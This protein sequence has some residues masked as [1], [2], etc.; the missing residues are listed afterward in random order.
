M[1]RI[2]GVASMHGLHVF[3]IFR[4]LFLVLAGVCFCL[5]AAAEPDPATAPTSGGRPTA[6]WRAGLSRRGSGTQEW[7]PHADYLAKKLAPRQF[8]IVPLTLDEFRP[9]IRARID[10]VITNTGHYVEL[11]GWR[12]DLAH[13]HHARRRPE[14]PGG[15]LWRH[16]HRPRRARRPEYLCRPARQ[17]PGGARHQGLRR[18][19]GASARSPQAG[20]DL[21]TTWPKPSNCRPRTRWSPASCAGRADAGFVRSDLIES[22]AA[23]GKLDLARSRSSASARHAAIPTA[24]APSFIRTGPSPSSTMSPTSHQGSADRAAQP[25]RRASRRACRRHPRLDPAAELPDGA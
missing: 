25:A 9:A 8:R 5:P 16:R 22:M 1:S 23:A 20:I 17:A 18:L 24:T 4:R 13:R 12:P 11:E 15:S 6:H 2:P 14:R 3:A 21:G 19:A 7:Q 10:L